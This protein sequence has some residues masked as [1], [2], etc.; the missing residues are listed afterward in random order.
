M[1][2]KTLAR[3]LNVLMSNKDLWEALQEHLLNLKTLDQQGLVVATSES[4]M[5]R[6]QGRLRLLVHLEQLP[7]QVKEAMNRKQET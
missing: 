5:F 4:E 7:E 1:L 6:L 3:K 2:D